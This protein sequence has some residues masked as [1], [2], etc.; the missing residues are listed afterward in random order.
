MI[1]PRL[2]HWN[3][4]T[5]F[6]GKGAPDFEKRKGRRSLKQTKSPPGRW[7]GNFVKKSIDESFEE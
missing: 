6:C 5:G 4:K 7:D 3:L 2:F 1:S